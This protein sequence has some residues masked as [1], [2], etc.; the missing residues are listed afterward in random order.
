MSFKDAGELKALFEDRKK[1]GVKPSDYHNWDEVIDL[2]VKQ[3]R[4]L[5]VAMIELWNDRFD[6]FLRDEEEPDKQ[7][8]KLS[9]MS[10]KYGQNIE[11]PSNRR[12]LFFALLAQKLMNTPGICSKRRK[13]VL[14][15]FLRF[16]DPVQRVC[17]IAI[18]T[19]FS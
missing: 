9:F 17:Q 14:L 7:V 1:K 4:E 15:E 13:G 16:F 3:A 6:P 5:E 8:Y 10:Q 11:L 18:A 12:A 2:T 19:N